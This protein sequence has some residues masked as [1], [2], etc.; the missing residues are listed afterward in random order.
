MRDVERSYFARRNRAFRPIALG[1][2]VAKVPARGV[3]P[4]MT[5]TRL[6]VM[7][8]EEKP[9]PMMSIR[10][11]LTLIWNKVAL[12]AP[13]TLSTVRSGAMKILLAVDGSIYTKRMLAYVAAH[14]E[15][16]GGRHQ[17]TLL[18]CAPG[19]AEHIEAC[20]GADVM[21]RFQDEQAD[22]VFKPIRAF[23]TQQR[24]EANYVHAAGNAAEV[25]AREAVSGKFDLL[26][27]G[28]HG[29][30]VVAGI[31]LGSVATKVLAKCSTPVLLIR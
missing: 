18:N 17:Y 25:I 23:F 16:L 20:V 13:R 6:A 30:G 29:Q 5:R 11:I 8:V 26:I 9:H 10:T 22:M 12:A 21:R 4:W 7:A 3:G 2:S 28:S 15:W 14:D 24:I 31:V 1:E 19:V 27:M